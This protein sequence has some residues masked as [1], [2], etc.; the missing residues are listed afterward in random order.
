MRVGPIDILLL[1]HCVGRDRTEAGDEIAER[2]AHDTG[3]GIFDLFWKADRNRRTELI[4]FD[5][6]GYQL[7]L[8][9]EIQSVAET[10]YGHGKA[11]SANDAPCGRSLYIGAIAFSPF[12]ASGK[13]RVFW[14]A[15]R[16]HHPSLSNYGLLLRS[17]EG[18]G[19]L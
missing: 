8:S 16:G 9:A 11:D 2:R 4:D 6:V 3:I 5:N 17:G 13:I 18:F 12:L 19:P 14:R 15:V 7:D 10:D 1:N